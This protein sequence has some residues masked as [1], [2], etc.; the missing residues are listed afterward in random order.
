MKRIVPVT[1]NLS[2][3]LPAL[4]L[5]F[6]ADPFYRA[7]TAGFKAPD[8]KQRVLER[9]FAYSLEEARRT[10]HCVVAGNPSLGAAAWLLPRAADVEAT[11]SDAKHTFLQ[12]LLG[13]IGYGNYKSILEYM[14]VRAKRCVD[15][16]A[17]Y[18]SI[19]GVHPAA[20]GTGLG[21][22][23]LAPTLRLATEQGMPCYLE[24]FSLRSVAFYSRLGFASVAEFREPTTDASYFVMC[25]AA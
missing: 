25:R 24:T 7:I 4:A 6:A 21:R 10:G 15:D 16:G 18:L 23:L 2:A 11:E 5:S 22:Q 19:V 8:E 9:Y 3:A 14:S 12:R 13:R 17:W 1:Q 20:Q